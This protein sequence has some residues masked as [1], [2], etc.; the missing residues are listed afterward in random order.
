MV[1]SNEGKY[2]CVYIGQGTLNAEMVKMFLESWGIRTM[3]SQES[4]G[5]TYGLTLGPMGEA[6]VYVPEA[7]YDQAL[8]LIESMEAGQYSDLEDQGTPDPSESDPEEGEDSNS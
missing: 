5:K 8:E 4:S 6:K 1:N 7:N 2:K 3:V